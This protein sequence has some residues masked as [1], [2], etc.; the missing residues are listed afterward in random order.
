MSLS[1][2]EHKE[3]MPDDNALSKALAER[4]ALWDGVTEHIRSNHKDVGGEW[5][6]YSKAA[7]W[8]FVIKSGKRTLIYLIPMSGYLKANLILGE[9]AV[10]AAMASGIPE[11]IK[12]KISEARQYAEGRS[13]MVDV[14]SKEDLRAVIELIGIK[15]RN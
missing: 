10:G 6:Y 14:K 13:F 3:I 2:F 11:Q 8:S 15:D 5:K 9:N 4:K 12:K 1:V 7:G